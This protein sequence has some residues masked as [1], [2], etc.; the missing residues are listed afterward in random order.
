MST[1]VAVEPWL[2]LPSTAGPGSYR[3]LLDLGERA[4]TAGWHALAVADSAFALGFHEST[5]ALA[6]L[7][8]R[9]RRARLVVACLSTLGLRDPLTVAQQWANLDAVSDGRMHLVACPGNRTGSRHERERAAF[10]IDY[11]EKLARTEEHLA[12][13]RTASRP[14]SVTFHGRRVHVDDL[15]F[16]PPFVQDRLPLWLTGNPGAEAG[17]QTLERVLGRVARLGDGW[18]TYN[19][20]PADLAPRIRLLHELRDRAVADG[21]EVAVPEGRLPVAVQVRFTLADTDQAA[22]DE[23]RAAWSTAST[24]GISEDDLTQVFAV[25]TPARALTLIDDLRAAGATAVALSP[26][27]R[28]DA[29]QIDR[30]TAELL[31]HLRTTPASTDAPRTPATTTAT[32]TTEADA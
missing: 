6:A 5:V 12:F 14:G 9:T 19:I 24:R 17:P 18:L 4:D 13:L 28:D 21:L 30:A 8:A 32:T 1:D 26:L 15:T 23:A 3:R 27:G 22:A 29:E 31:P 10:G 7:A 16:V 2:V 25:G 20:R 11:D